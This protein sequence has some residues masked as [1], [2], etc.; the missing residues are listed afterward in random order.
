[1]LLNEFKSRDEA[2]R[3]QAEYFCVELHCAM[4]D[5]EG[6]LSKLKADLARQVERRMTAGRI[7]QTQKFVREFALK[8][9]ELVRMLDALGHHYPCGHHN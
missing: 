3:L 7:R 4:E 6:Q 1:M 5:V 2:D 9:R 8:R